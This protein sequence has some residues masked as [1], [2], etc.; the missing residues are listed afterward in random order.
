[1][2]CHPETDPRGRNNADHPG[3]RARFG[4]QRDLRRRRLAFLDT[5]SRNR[6]RET[7]FKCPHG[8]FAGLF[9]A[10]GAVLLARCAGAIRPRPP[11]GQ[12]RPPRLLCTICPRSNLD[13]SFHARKELRNQTPPRHPRRFITQSGRRQCD[14]RP[15]HDVNDR[16]ISLRRAP[17]CRLGP[18]NI[19]R[20]FAHGNF[21]INIR[22]QLR[23]NG[24]SAHVSKFTN[25]RLHTLAPRRKPPLAVAP[26]LKYSAQPSHRSYSGHRRAGN[27]RRRPLCGGSRSC[28]ARHPH[29]RPKGCLWPDGRRGQRLRLR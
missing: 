6:S 18:Q 21:Q 14:G 3:N 9:P 11:P 7:G 24:C 13:I 1:M 22:S 4:P 25:L 28:R 27:L 26:H 8:I 12:V 23:P 5:L 17:S 10:I 2:R 15:G 29:S 20:S 16:D 19:G